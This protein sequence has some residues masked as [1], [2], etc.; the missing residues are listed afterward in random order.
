MCGLCDKETWWTRVE[1]Q[2]VGADI[3][4]VYVSVCTS[5]VGGTSGGTVDLYEVVNRDTIVRV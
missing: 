5:G 3:T 2:V 4:C 1:T